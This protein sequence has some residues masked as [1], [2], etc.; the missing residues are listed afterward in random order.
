M[1]NALY[2]TRKNEGLEFARRVT[3]ALGSARLQKL[4]VA[5]AVAGAEPDTV[6]DLIVA[7]LGEH[8]T[9]LVE[10]KGLR[11]AFPK[12]VI[13]ITS[14][15]LSGEM[16]AEVYRAGATAVVP[17]GALGD[18]IANLTQVFEAGKPKR[19]GPLDDTMVEEFHDLA[20]GRL[21][22]DAVARGLDISVSGLAK[23]VGLTPSA[24]SKRPHARAA[25][26]A[27][28]EIEFAVAALRRLLGSDARVRA[29][30]NAPHPD[31]GGDA[32]LALLTK[33]SAKDL[34]DYVR[35]ALSGQPT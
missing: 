9:A 31:L 13:V 25:Q 34:A 18:A 11:R 7:G 12:T 27:L 10:I 26:N 5:K 32:P 14:R 19:P 6:P 21:D 23:A 29:W 2:V 17:L 8:V 15:K 30:L 33:G 22:A 16:S 3:A 1:L 28:R 20:T 35:G 4:T 24:L